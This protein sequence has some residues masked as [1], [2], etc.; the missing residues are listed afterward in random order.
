MPIHMAKLLQRTYISMLNGTFQTIFQHVTHITTHN[1]FI[2]E[3]YSFAVQKQTVGVRN[4]CKRHLFQEG[5][6]ISTKLISFAALQYLKIIYV[7]NN[8]TQDKNGC[9]DISDKSSIYM[10]KFVAAKYGRACLVP[11]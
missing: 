8:S 1:Y 6:T 7:M 10:L 9:G 3:R 4:L 11:E 5:S 2:I